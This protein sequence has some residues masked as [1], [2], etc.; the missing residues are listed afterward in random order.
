[1][2]CVFWL[3]RR[4][5]LYFGCEEAVLC[6]LAVKKLYCVFSLWRS[7]I[8]YF[9]CEEAVLCIL[10]V[11]KLYCVFWLWWSCIV[12]FGF[13]EA[14]L[15]I[16]AVKKVY[17]ALRKNVIFEWLKAFDKL[18]H[19]YIFLIKW[20]VKIVHFS[21]F[22]PIII[23]SVRIKDLFTDAWIRRGRCIN[24][25]VGGD[26]KYYHGFVLTVHKCII[27]IKLIQNIKTYFFLF[28]I[29]N[30]LKN[31]FFLFH[32][33]PETKTKQIVLGFIIFSNN[34]TRSMDDE[35]GAYTGV[36]TPWMSE[37]IN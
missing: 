22:L 4:C 9:G 25:I 3:W 24:I 7:C 11:K 35:T 26:L 32:I 28:L 31:F 8:V 19:N 5:I 16:L 2:Y 10:T 20:S 14:V 34:W 1:M 36:V 18:S 17:C 21:S 29:E 15:C 30:W 37:I 13:D 27:K 33:S 12:Y 6:I 23:D